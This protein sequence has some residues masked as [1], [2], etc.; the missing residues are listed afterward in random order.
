MIIVCSSL[1]NKCLIFT[2]KAKTTTRRLG[3][4]RVGADSGG[5]KS[6]ILGCHSETAFSFN[7]NNCSRADLSKLVGRETRRQKSSAKVVGKRLQPSRPRAGV[8]DI[9]RRGSLC[10]VLSK[11]YSHYT[12][13]LLLLRVKLSSR[14]EGEATCAR[15]NSNNKTWFLETIVS[16]RIIR[17]GRRGSTLVATMT[18]QAHAHP[19]LKK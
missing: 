16:P 11:Y 4:A 2:L 13:L 8:K 15:H 7:L 18:C 10:H 12:V 3:H 17:I 6:A 1:S 5:A 19:S 9:G 14:G